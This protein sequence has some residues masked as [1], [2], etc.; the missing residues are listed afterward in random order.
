MIKTKRSEQFGK[1][2]FKLT[3]PNTPDIEDI[4]MTVA[5]MVDGESLTAQNICV[6]TGI[7][8]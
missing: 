4:G 5:C 8:L 3:S 7:G 6:D 1:I 2:K